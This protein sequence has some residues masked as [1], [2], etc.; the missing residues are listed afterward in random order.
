MAEYTKD[1]DLVEI[2]KN[3]SKRMD[4]ALGLVL[5]VVRKML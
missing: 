2:S 5:L 4:Q 3:Y 1:P